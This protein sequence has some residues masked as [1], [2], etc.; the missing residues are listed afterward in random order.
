MESAVVQQHRNKLRCQS[1]E[2]GRAVMKNRAARVLSIACGGCLD[3]TPILPRLKDFAGEI[4][5]NDFEPAALQLAEQRLGSS[6][7]RYRL[8]PGNVIRV[9]R[10]LADYPRFALVLAGGLFDY[11]SRRA[12]VVLL[13]AIYE[14]LLRPGG[15][16][17]FT[18]IAEGN[19]WRLL[20][21]YGANWTL[22]ERSEAG[23]I[24]ICREAGMAISSVSVTRENTGLTLITRVVR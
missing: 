22:I 23:I 15:I 7:T 8:V 17:L 5:L 13:R 18:N 19:P 20:M 12:M 4:V 3:W 6:T 24:G 21:E 16:L 11:L 14:D 1:L 9:A 2:I 10:R